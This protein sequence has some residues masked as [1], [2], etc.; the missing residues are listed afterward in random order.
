LQV[1]L[2]S[3]VK[4]LEGVTLENAYAKLSLAFGSFKTKKKI[5]KFL[6]EN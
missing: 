6:N 3:G 1:I 4:T 5:F 2:K